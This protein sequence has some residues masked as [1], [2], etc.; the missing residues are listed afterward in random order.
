M[1]QLQNGAGP[2]IFLDADT[3]AKP[4]AVAAASSA[5]DNEPVCCGTYASRMAVQFVGTWATK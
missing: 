1:S 4:A 3:E 2:A 5:A